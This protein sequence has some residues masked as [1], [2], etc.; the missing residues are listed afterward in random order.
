MVAIS[1]SGDAKCWAMIS[2]H[3]PWVRTTS[4]RCSRWSSV[5][6]VDLPGW[7][8]GPEDIGKL[9][10]L[11]LGQHLDSCHLCARSFSASRRQSILLSPD[12]AP[13]SRSG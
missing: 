3:G 1:S 10:P 11:L 2:R 8:S 6:V 13:P 5:D 4:S 12:G 9:Q 7:R